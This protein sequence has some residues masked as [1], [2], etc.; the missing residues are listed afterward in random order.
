MVLVCTENLLKLLTFINLVAFGVKQRD[1]ARVGA[2]RVRQQDF[3]CVIG[4][5]VE[6]LSLPYAVEFFGKT[7]FATCATKVRVHRK[8][9][10]KKIKCIRNRSS[11][12]PC[13][14]NTHKAL[15]YQYTGSVI[16]NDNNNTIYNAVLY[17]KSVT[18]LTMQAEYQLDVYI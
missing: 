8:L 9:P 5:V 3:V 2:V 1:I 17:K 6:A 18:H 14:A 10:I 4:D 15:F 7:L 13:Y 11:E 12:R 16:D